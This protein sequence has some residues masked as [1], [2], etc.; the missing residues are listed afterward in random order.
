MLKKLDLLYE[1]FNKYQIKERLV[2]GF[3]IAS[4][5]PAVVAAVILIVM[6]VIAKSY[7]GALQNYGFAQGDVG[8]AMT[9]FAEARSTLRG[10]IGYEAES[11]IE[12]MKTA[13][14]ESIENFTESFRSLE[15]FMI[16]DEDKAIYQD[17]A[18]KLPDYWEIDAQ[19]LDMGSNSNDQLSR[20][21]QD[22]AMNRQKPMYDEINNQL[23]SIMD[24]KVEHG[25]SISETMTIISTV[26]VIVIAVIIIIAIASS[27]R[28]G[29]Y[30]AGNIS[31]PLVKLKDRL[32]EF[33]QGDLTS[34]F[35]EVDTNDEVADIIN[36]A[37][38]MAETLNFIIYDMDYI[39]GEMADSNYA[40]RSKDGSKYT[41]EFRQIFESL[42]RLRDTMIDTIRYIEESS[43]QV[44]A[45]S[46]NLADSSQSLAEGAT[47]QAGAVEELQ[48]TI[49]TI[50]DASKSAAASAEEAYHQSQ[51]YADVADRSSNDM[52]E[53]LEA[54]ERINETSQRIGNI[55]SEIES[56]D[57][58]K[59]VL[60]EIIV[61]TQSLGP[62]IVDSYNNRHIKVGV[63]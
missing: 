26:L 40:V 52:K 30:I 18:D 42:K 9:Y 49:T 56:I 15:R 23:V 57:I 41:K 46:S 31:A 10:C 6:V 12:S 3:I 32:A 11:A 50:S 54:M 33:S 62:T 35:P 63:G 43:I 29:N 60:G 4:G 27:I 38:E 39:L 44:S 47:E 16:T 48:A 34:P 25:N 61:G 7:A 21:A 5:V 17:I 14:A 24:T 36:S 28:L 19:I 22:M 1:R 45:G 20:V 37:K 53:M 13:H 55:I 51:K 59:G 58:I 8:K 2:R